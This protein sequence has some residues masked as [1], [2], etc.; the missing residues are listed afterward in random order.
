MTTNRLVTTLFICCVACLLPGSQQQAA[1]AESPHPLQ[2][3]RFRP[4]GGLIMLPVRIGN[5]TLTFVLD[6]GAT[7]H[8]YDVSLE[9]QEREEGFIKRR[10]DFESLQQ[11]FLGSLTSPRGRLPD[12]E[13]C[14][15]HHRIRQAHGQSSR[16]GKSSVSNQPTHEI[17]RIAILHFFEWRFEWSQH[18]IGICSAQ[19]H[20]QSFGRTDL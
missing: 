8:V 11:R 20:T 16:T 2:E 12:P 15:T 6:S 7:D 4:D 17:R 10:I 19:W 5:D 14:V 9:N 18:P 13:C 3:F 1:L